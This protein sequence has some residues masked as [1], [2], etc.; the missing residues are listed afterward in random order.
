MASWVCLHLKDLA[1]HRVT[2]PSEVLDLGEKVAVKVLRID[3][4][5]LRI[6]LGMKT[7]SEDP[8]KDVSLR[9]PINMRVFGKIANLVDY[10]VFVAV[11]PGVE[12]LLHISK[13]DAL[14]VGNVGDEIEVVVLEVNEDL[15]RISLGQPT[16]VGLS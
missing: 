7:L 12:G 10:G 11:E 9:Y 3:H 16:S 5:T 15:R 8:W 6:S 1:W 2:H 13:M 14:R 4:V